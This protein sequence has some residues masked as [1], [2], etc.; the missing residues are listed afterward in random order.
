MH[1]IPVM[2][3]PPCRCAFTMRHIRCPWSALTCILLCVRVPTA[4]FR[5]EYRA[6][7]AADPALLARLHEL[8]KD[9]NALRA[10]V[11]LAERARLE[12]L[13]KGYRRGAGYKG[14]N[15]Q[16]SH[17]ALSGCLW[18]HSVSTRH[19]LLIIFSPP[20]PRPHTRIQSLCHWY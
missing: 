12:R 18:C 3:A 15:H 6:A 13:L 19:V 4:V 1:I 9:K 8:H 5:A 10:V 11:D 17:G 16:S 14:E 2:I 20:C 7:I